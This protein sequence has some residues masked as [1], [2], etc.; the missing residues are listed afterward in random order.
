[1]E[2]L[3]IVAGVALIAVI[4]YYSWLAAKKRR[5]AFQTWSAAHGWNYISQRDRGTYE[6]FRFLD[7]LNQGSNRY[8]FD[9]LSGEWEGRNAEA[10]TFHFE[11]HSSD[12]KGHRRTHHHYIGIVAISIEREFPEL[13][14]HP[15]GLFS[16]IG[17][18]FG[19]D[20]I[21]FESVEFSKKFSVRSENKKLAFDFCNT[22]MMEYLLQHSKTALE[23]EGN[24]LAI[25]DANRLN[26]DEVEP[27]L[28]HLSKIRSLMPEYLFRD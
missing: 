14:I 9:R 10:F 23:L 7:K 22:G 28:N 3:L 17:Q 20:D 11:T 4:A 21:D 13:R 16:K 18:F 26:P 5:E 12:S 19:Y 25:Y 27:Y 6:R 15:E 2:V 1:M 8:A 24:T